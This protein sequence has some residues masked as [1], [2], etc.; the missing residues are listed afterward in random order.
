MISFAS[1]DDDG[2]STRLGKVHVKMEDLDQH[3]QYE[4]V[5][6]SVRF[7]SLNDFD[8]CE[9]VEEFLEKIKEEISNDSNTNACTRSSLFLQD[10]PSE[11]M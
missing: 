6:T 11:G 2:S 1:F 4:E 5:D 3:D 9:R 8:T 7:H 10:F